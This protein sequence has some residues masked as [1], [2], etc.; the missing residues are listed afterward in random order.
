MK[1]DKQSYRVLSMVLNLSQLV[2]A[3]LSFYID[4][5]RYTDKSADDL[6]GGWTFVVSF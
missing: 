6:T 3:A 4:N 5:Q 1:H 2:A